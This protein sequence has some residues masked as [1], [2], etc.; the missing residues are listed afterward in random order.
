MGRWEIHEERKPTCWLADVGVQVGGMQLIVGGS[1]ALLAMEPRRR[2]IK[3][4]V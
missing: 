2:Y 1:S 4:I 3:C